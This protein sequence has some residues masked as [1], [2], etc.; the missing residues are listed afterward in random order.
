MKVSGD[1]PKLEGWLTLPE[2]AAALGVTKQMVH[3]M[4]FDTLRVVGDRAA[5]IVRESEVAT[6]RLR[7]EKDAE[8]M[9]RKRAERGLPP[10]HLQKLV[11]RNQI[12]P[13]V[14]TITAITG[15]PHADFEFVQA[16]NFS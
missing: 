3:K 8:E 7:K 15:S 12:T 2:V 5:Y 4:E 6:I 14:A 16:P 9:D 11:D 13:N 10:V 1:A